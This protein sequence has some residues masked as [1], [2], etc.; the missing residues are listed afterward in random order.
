MPPLFR[1]RNLLAIN[2]KYC[3]LSVSLAALSCNLPAAKNVLVAFCTEK[4]GG[5]AA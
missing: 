4:P 1:C 5:G 2:E 3:R